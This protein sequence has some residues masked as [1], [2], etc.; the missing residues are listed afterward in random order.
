METTRTILKGCPALK[1]YP[2]SAKGLNRSRGR[3]S[4]DQASERL[5][6]RVLFRKLRSEA[7]RLVS[8]PEQSHEGFHSRDFPT[9]STNA[10]GYAAAQARTPDAGGLRACSSEAGRLPAPT[11]GYCHGRGSAQ[12]PAAL[13]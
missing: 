7:F 12:L 5:T 8:Q 9:A 1:H 11:A 10:G 4:F 6:T 13:G 2:L 3:D